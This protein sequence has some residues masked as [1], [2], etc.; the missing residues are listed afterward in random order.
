[1][2][3]SRLIELKPS[4]RNSRILGGGERD[5]DYAGTH[6]YERLNRVLNA[7]K[8][9]Q[10]VEAICRKYYK[11]SSVVNGSAAA[12]WRPIPYNLCACHRPRRGEFVQQN[13]G[14]AVQHDSPAESRLARWLA[15]GGFSPCLCTLA[16]CHLSSD[17]SPIVCWS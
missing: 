11:S 1:M 13:V 16:N 15:P 6:V 17:R 10:R 7:E 4:E 8:F 9:Y 3:G 5:R 12:Q 2:R 14:F